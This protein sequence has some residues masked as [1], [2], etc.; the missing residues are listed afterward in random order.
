MSRL[1]TEVKRFTIQ[2]RSIGRWKD[3][4]TFAEK[5]DEYEIDTAFGIL[6]ANPEKFKGFAE[7]Q[8][9]EIVDSGAFRADGSPIL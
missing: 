5:A 8:V 4:L 9:V 7:W 2:A 6:E 3:V 1:G